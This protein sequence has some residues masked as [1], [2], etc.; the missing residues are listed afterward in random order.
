VLAELDVERSGASSEV[1]QPAGAAQVHCVSHH[2]RGER[3][4]QHCFFLSIVSYP[5]L[6][7]AMIDV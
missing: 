7:R 4:F 6:S 5:G 1:E 2:A 3:A